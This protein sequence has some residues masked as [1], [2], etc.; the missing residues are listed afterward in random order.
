M[1]GNGTKIHVILAK[2]K[3]ISIQLTGANI[4]DSDPVIP[5]L[6]YL[7]NTGI[8]R[9]VADK[10]YDDDKIRTALADLKIKADIPPRSNRREHRFHDNS[11][12]KWR[13]RVEAFFGKIKEN[14][15]IA[16]RVDKLDVTFNSFIA[17]ALIKNLVC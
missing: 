10:G 16:L 1:A 13:W 17:L 5:M 11:I 14:R 15:R 12:Y 8:K 9:F 2:D 6:N 3:P 4:H 7:K